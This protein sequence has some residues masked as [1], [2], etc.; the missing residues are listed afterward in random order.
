MLDDASMGFRKG[1]R[2]RRTIGAATYRRKRIFLSALA[3]NSLKMRGK[4]LH[5]KSLS[6][7]DD[8]S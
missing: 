6:A 7:A 8:A 5:E 1:G 2:T 3:Y 4:A